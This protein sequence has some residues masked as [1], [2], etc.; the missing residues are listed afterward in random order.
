ML[1][2][3]RVHQPISFSLSSG[4]Q[5]K[6]A[7]KDLRTNNKGLGVALSV[8]ELPKDHYRQL[9]EAG[10]HRYLLRIETANPDLYHK[11]HPPDHS[12]ER[13]VECLKELRDL[14]YQVRFRGENLCS[15]H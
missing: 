1:L 5:S 14:G 8:G 9:R 11:L 4:Q 2:A 12:W 3:S 6:E 7:R 10:A 13:R 15:E